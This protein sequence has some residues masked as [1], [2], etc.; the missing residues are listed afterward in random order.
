M[1]CA[2]ATFKIAAM[3][4]ALAPTVLSAQLPPPPPPG[5]P[6]YVQ[7][8]QDSYNNRSLK[9]YSALF[10]EN[11]KTYVDGK[12]VST[13]RDSLLKRVKSEFD[14]NQYVQSMSWAQGSQIIVMDQVTGCIP[15]KPNAGAV[16][17]P[18]YKARAVRYDLGDNN[19]ITAVHVLEA[20]RAWNMH[21]GTQ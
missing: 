12:I 2:D 9:D 7:L 20:N 10:D 11:V 3:C 21:P 14:N 18:C 15:K 8:L 16:Y 6:N 13:D 4:F 17:H 19:K 1:R 5:F